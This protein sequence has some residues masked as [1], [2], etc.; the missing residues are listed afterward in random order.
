MRVGQPGV[1]R[2]QRHLDRERQREREEEPELQVRRN[3]EV[4]ELLEVEAVDAPDRVVQVGEAEDREQHQDAARHR[5]EDELHRRVHAPL[6]AP[7]PDQEVHRDQHRVPEDVEEEEV[8]RDEHADHRALEQ[9]D[10]HAE[11][12][13][14][15]VHRLPGGQQS[16]RREESGQDQEQ[17]ADAVDPDQIADPERRDPG[18]ALHELKLR[19]CRVEPGPE[20][21]RFEKHQHRHHQRDHPDRALVLLRL[22]EEQ[23]GDGAEHRQHEERGQDRKGHDV[24]STATE[25]T[26][27]YR[28]PGDPMERARCPPSDSKP[29]P[30]TPW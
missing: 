13:G 25:V 6:V 11:R 20:Q 1:E 18:V 21:E 4:V 14:V 26:E 28:A 10:A 17:Q 23:Q 3:R 19:R 29:V 16:E 15:L 30:W 12:P 8:E 5:I 9:Q 2:E 27:T 22:L 7:D 24:K